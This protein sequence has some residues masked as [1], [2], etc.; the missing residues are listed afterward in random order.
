MPVVKKIDT[1]C[2]KR[3]EE[4]SNNSRKQEHLENPLDNP[5]HLKSWSYHCVKIYSI[6]IDIVYKDVINFIKWYNGCKTVISKRKKLN[7]PAQIID[8][9]VKY[10]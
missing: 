6:D 7:Y 8:M 2:S 4:L 1:I 10:H 5:K 3:G 9:N